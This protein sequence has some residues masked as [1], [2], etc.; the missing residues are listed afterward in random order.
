MEA[1]RVDYVSIDHETEQTADGGHS[2]VTDVGFFVLIVQG[3]VGILLG[4]Q[5]TVIG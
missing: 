5:T 3:Y 2:Q 4:W 1:I